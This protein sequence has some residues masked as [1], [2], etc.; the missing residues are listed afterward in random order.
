MN[1][2]RSGELLRNV[3][4]ARLCVLDGG[5]AE[6]AQEWAAQVTNP[7]YSR[8][9]YI[10]KGDAYILSADGRETPL[11]PGRCYLLPTGFSFRHACRTQMEQ[12]YFHI[13]L[14]DD[15]GG[16]LL[17]ACRQ[18]LSTVA[19]GERIERLIG[20][21]MDDGLLSGLRLRQELTRDVLELLDR[22]GVEPGRAQYAR[23]V[24]EAILYI[25][26][27]LSMQLTVGELAACAHVSESTLEKTFRAQTGMTIGRYIDEAVFFRAEE[28]LRHTEMSA[29]QI[30]EELGFC[31]QFY[32]SRRFS[33]R[34]G[35]SP[36]RYRKARPI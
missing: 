22:G 20:L 33:R 1:I 24:R 23:C 28:L 9:Y 32:F 15:M 29:A 2:E 35:L 27:H 7:P 14:D 3:N 31:D 26:D 16:D 4:G 8:L 17:R 18:P 12:L 21:T 13:R 6:G 30:S 34:Y 25:R 10:C 11:E 5:H 19:G 36:Q